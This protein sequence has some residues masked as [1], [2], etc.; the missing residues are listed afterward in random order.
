MRPVAT[1]ALLFL[2]LCHCNQP[3]R[4]SEQNANGVKSSKAIAHSS[5][6]KQDSLF[7]HYWNYWSKKFEYKGAV[8]FSKND[9]I[10]SWV[11]GEAKPGQPLTLQMPMQIASISKPFCAVAIMQ[12][13][14][15][16]KLTLS[17]KLTLFFPDLNYPDISIEN[18]LSHSSGLPE[19][20][21]FMTL[22]WNSKSS[23]SCNEEIIR[24]M[25]RKRP[26]LRFKPGAKHEYINTNF[27]L[28][29]SIVE[30]VSGQ[31]YSQY[32]KENI[33]I[34]LGMQHTRVLECNENFDSLKVRGYGTNGS[35]YPKDFPDRTYGD[36]NII[37]T[38]EDLH[39]FYLGLKGNKL[40][41]ANVK[42]EIFKTRFTNTRNNSD[43]CLGWRKKTLFGEP[44]L[45]HTGSWQGFISNF[46]FS[47]SGNKCF[48][49]L[50]NQPL[51]ESFEGELL[52]AVFYPEEMNKIISSKP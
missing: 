29:A 27:I 5:N 14:G 20:G 24:S 19:Y 10:F 40:L 32:L 39:K 13:V 38:V 18:L 30:K 47:K 4:N 1:L 21:E 35:I 52:T 45:F 17:D 12:L 33:F 25:S 16:G 11:N 9:T 15:Q 43:Y 23:P 8:L 41:A 50:S 48:A 26:A 7:R 44:W 2:F 37:S 49:T 22:N 42:E 34:P 28:L 3:G 6:P 51:D 36:K 46:Y 31:K